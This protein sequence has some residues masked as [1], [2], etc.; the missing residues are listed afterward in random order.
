MSALEPKS[1]PAEPA[2]KA[3]ADMK[4]LNS[5]LPRVDGPDKVSGR[6][7]YTADVRLPEMVFIRL[8]LSPYPRA[9]LHE[10][11]L[12]QARD[13]EGVVYAEANERGGNEVRYHGADSVLAIVAATSPE[14]AED[15]LRAIT[16]DLEE[17]PPV[18]TP[19][20]S[21]AKDAPQISSRGN[22]GGEGKSG[23]LEDAERE[24]EFS[25]AVVDQTYTLPVQHHACLET[26]A[27]TVDYRGADEATV[28]ASTQTVTGANGEAARWLKLAADKV[29]VV[30]HHMG[31][32]FGSKFGLG[33]EGKVACEVALAL[34]RPAALLLTRR[35][36]FIMAGN[37]SGSRQHLRG[38][39]TKDGKITALISDADKYGG[40][41]GG[42]LPTTNRPYIYSVP[43]HYTETRSVRTATDPNRAMRAPGHP[44]ASFAMESLVDE[45]AYA[46]GVDPLTFRKNNLENP[47]YQRQLDRV[48]AE[49]GWAEHPHKTQPAPADGSVQIGIGFGVSVWSSGSSAGSFC[50]VRVYPDGR[51]TSTAGTQDLGTGSRTY[52]AAIVAE[53]FGLELAQV[54]ARIGESG[55]PASAGSGGSV[56][57]GSSAPAVKDGAHKAREAFEAKLSAALGAPVGGYVWEGGRVHVAGDPTRG[58]DWRQACAMLGTDPI[59]AMGEWRESLRSEGVQGAQAVKVAV[60]TLTGAIKPLEMV[61]I[62][63]CGLVLNR[64]A[65]RSQING[66]QIQ[67][68]SYGLLEER[69]YDPELGLLMTGNFE[70]YKIAGAQE[71]PRIVSLL[72]DDDERLAVMGMAEANCIPGHGALACAVYNACGVRMRDLPLTP[73]KLVMAL[74]GA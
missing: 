31:G 67:A 25:D 44:Q 1:P 50:E 41:G 7:R 21:K 43:V 24:L 40:M 69:V 36:E 52:V 39:A 56:T 11:E 73:D 60:D 17:L 20:Q 51:V 66:G 45:L 65:A 58:L 55:F 12:E 46:V 34:K 64:L 10:L 18:V 5:D 30:T 4:L 9:I 57:T 72:D 32:G 6:A 27:V 47:V 63:N 38:G 29:K 16:F 28:Y 48:A 74:H 62:Q 37:R 19:E 54:T 68:L 53:E 59:Q 3:R 70:T 2:W 33:F 22:V 71:M 61:F 13:V 49:I 26:H 14:A 23:N 8:L 15:G 35:D 42:A